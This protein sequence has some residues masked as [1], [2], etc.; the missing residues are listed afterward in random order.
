MALCM[1]GLHQIS[2][3]GNRLIQIGAWRLGEVDGSHASL[4]HKDEGPPPDFSTWTRSAGSPHGILFGDRLI[5]I[6]A[7]RLGEVD[8]S[9]RN[10]AS[11]MVPLISP[12]EH[13]L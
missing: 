8:G 11:W 2:L 5:L 6:G 7:W 4:A 9:R 13:C 1:G 10:R 12:A 3:Y